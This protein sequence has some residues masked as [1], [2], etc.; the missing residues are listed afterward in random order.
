MYQDDLLIQYLLQNARVEP[1]EIVSGV[2]FLFEDEEI[3]YIGQSTDVFVRMRRHYADPKK[4]FDKWAF[5]K[6]PVEDLL[7]V[8]RMYI[9]MF[10]P[11]LNQTGIS[12]YRKQ[13]RRER[14]AQHKFI[15]HRSGVYPSID[16]LPNA[17]RSASERL[18]DL[19]SVHTKCTPAKDLDEIEA[20]QTSE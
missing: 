6:V 20:L 19:L 15:V 14:H 11:Y 18:S 3:V 4:T 1:L 2:Y 8:E 17:Q 7:D 16:P 9:K 10:Q 13:R 5:I 12:P